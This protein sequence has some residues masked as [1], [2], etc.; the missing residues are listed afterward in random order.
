MA[1]P[2]DDGDFMK[3][4]FIRMKEMDGE[5]NSKISDRKPLMTN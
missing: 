2:A 5:P 3:S 4:M 1:W